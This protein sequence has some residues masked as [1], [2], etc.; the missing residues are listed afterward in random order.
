VPTFVPRRELGA[1]ALPAGTGIESDVIVIDH[2]SAACCG[3]QR[4]GSISVA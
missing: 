2:V 4:G 1:Y 3:L